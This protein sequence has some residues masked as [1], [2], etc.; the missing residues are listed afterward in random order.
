MPMI[1]NAES[2]RVFTLLSAFEDRQITLEEFMDGLGNVSS[3]TLQVA[4]TFGMLR[5][6]WHSFSARLGSARQIC[7]TLASSVRCLS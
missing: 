3:E 2:R 4:A 1:A 5:E 7:Q 6:P